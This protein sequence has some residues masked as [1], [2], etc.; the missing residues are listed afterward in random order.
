MEFY[1]SVFFMLSGALCWLVDVYRDK[2]LLI[3]S[4]SEG[5]SRLF[6]LG[7][8][9]ASLG[10]SMISNLSF[11]RQMAGAQ[12]FLAGN[13]LIVLILG[14]LVGQAYPKLLKFTKG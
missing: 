11:E 7:F 8:F 2:V 4:D 6:I 10:I 14:F 12:M 9:L 1:V 13:L 5:R 3:P